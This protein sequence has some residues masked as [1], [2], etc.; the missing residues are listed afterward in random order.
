M[1]P[2]KKQNLFLEKFNV[3]DDKS[4][5]IC[6]VPGCG[7]ELKGFTV[8][9][10][11]RHF[12]NVHK[13]VAENFE[14][15]NEN[16][17]PGQNSK[18]KIKI[19]MDK[20]TLCRASIKIVTK[21]AI[22]LKILDSEGF[23]ELVGPMHEALGVTINAHNISEKLQNVAQ[24]LK[25]IIS[26][27]LKNKLFSLKIDSATRH[28]RSILGVNAQFSDDGQIKIRTLGMI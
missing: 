16:I 26:N 21:D 5:S 18:K 7:K 27:E 12:L 6:K 2:A 10:L 28:G 15:E 17:V 24:H 23:R 8:G 4:K 3:L 22:P 9:N 19:L 13:N 20:A 1:A 11:K 14:G 25:E